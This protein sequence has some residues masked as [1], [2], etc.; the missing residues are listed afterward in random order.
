MLE[1]DVT[2]FMDKISPTPLLMIVSEW[3]TTT[4]SDIAL[5]HYALVQGT[6]KLMVIKADHYAAYVEKFDETS[7]AA[8]DWFLEHLA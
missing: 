7:A 3:D 4:P 6:K 1:Y 8:R 5:D 2:G